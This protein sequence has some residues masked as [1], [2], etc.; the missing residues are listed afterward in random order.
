MSV[1]CLNVINL[2]VTHDINKSM[3]CVYENMCCQTYL[4]RCVWCWKWC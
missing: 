1:T 4:E 3:M 2:G